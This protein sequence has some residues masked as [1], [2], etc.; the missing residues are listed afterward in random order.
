MG[1]YIFPQWIMVSKEVTKELIVTLS[2]IECL[3]CAW[4]CAV[5]YL[6]CLHSS[7]SLHFHHEETGLGCA[8]AFTG[9]VV[10]SG[11]AE[12]ETEFS[13]TLCFTYS[14]YNIML[15]IPEDKW[16]QIA[17][18]VMPVFEE[19]HGRKGR[20]NASLNAGSSGSEQAMATGLSWDR[21]VLALVPVLWLTVGPGSP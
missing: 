15:P 1:F 10:E 4:K 11:G 12:T 9:H 19:I 6:N 2:F 3:L 14:C 18:K 20:V 16:F 13:L 5:F 17:S 8:V 21:G 7:S